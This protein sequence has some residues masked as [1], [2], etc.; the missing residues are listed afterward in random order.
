MQ[1]STDTIY[2]YTF[3][4]KSYLLLYM[5]TQDLDE[6]N[7]LETSNFR[8]DK[9]K[10]RLMHILSFLCSYVLATIGKFS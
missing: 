1:F 5:N 3:L 7:T 9:R 4:R 2:E 6:Y 10:S 8:I